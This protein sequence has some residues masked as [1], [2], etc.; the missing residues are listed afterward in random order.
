MEEFLPQMIHSGSRKKPENL[1]NP[2]KNV[3]PRPGTPNL[4]GSNT[5]P[6]GPILLKF[7]VKTRK[8]ILNSQKVSNPYTETFRS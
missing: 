8:S 6:A 1:T 2:A 5:A 7:W 3:L 4:Q